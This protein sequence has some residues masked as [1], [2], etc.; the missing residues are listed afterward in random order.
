MFPQFL[1]VVSTILF[2]SKQ[3][4]HSDKDAAGGAAASPAASAD[5]LIFGTVFEVQSV[6]AT[7]AAG[8]SDNDSCCGEL[9]PTLRRG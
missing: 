6:E 8:D 3:D 7:S 5:G 9:Q 4:F 2:G 1:T